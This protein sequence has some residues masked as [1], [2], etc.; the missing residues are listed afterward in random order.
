MKT[1]ISLKLAIGMFSISALLAVVSCN[2]DETAAFEPTEL[3]VSG[4]DEVAPGD[5][6]TY[7][8][9]RYNGETYTWTVPSSGVTIIEGEGTPAIT[10][11][12]TAAGSGDITVAARGVNGTK[13]VKVLTAAPLASAALDSGVVLSEG[14]TGKVLI[15]FD[16]AI[17]TAPKLTLMPDAGVMGSAVSAIEQVDDHTF[18]VTYTAGAGDGMDKL[19]V[20]EAVTSEFFGSK[21]MDTVL[22]FD[23][24][25]VDNTSAT[26]ELFASRTPVNDSTTVTLSAAFS[27]ALSTTDS[28]KISVNGLLTAY[29]TDARMT[30]QDGITWTYSF[31]PTGG[32]NELATVSVSS[33]PAD[34]AGN[35]TEA[36]E[37]APIIIQIKND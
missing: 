35:P 37:I 1:R 15:S 23:L 16:Q 4:P 13:T 32:A 24:Y 17:A 21:A 36:S 14:K 6:A 18:Q 12:F 9:D 8:A 2:D 31:Q 29:V 28:V 5:T 3:A 11:T 10:V 20:A 7:T 26:G 30:T 22:V 33:S 19:S 27:E 25:Q 34:L